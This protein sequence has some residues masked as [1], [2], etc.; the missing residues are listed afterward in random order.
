MA[1]IRIES[2]AKFAKAV[3]VVAFTV[4]IL[5]S[6][7]LWINEGRFFPV[8]KL[9]DSIPNP[10]AP[11]DLALPAVFVVLSLVWVFYDKKRIGLA[12]LGCLAV[13]L[14]QDQMRWQPWVYLYLLMLLS[15]LIPFDRTEREKSII[16]TLQWIIAGVYVWSGI[17][18][19]N[20]NFINGTFRLMVDA[21]GS[22]DLPQHWMKIGYAVPLVECS[23]GLALL[24]SRFRRA[25]VYMA[26]ATHIIIL[27]GLGPLGLSQ[28]TVVYPWN[29]AM[30]CFV[31]LLF[32]SPKEN[33]IA[34]LREVWSSKL[35]MMLVAP[36]WIFPV[37]NFF[38]Y[39]DHYLSFSLYSDKPSKFYIAIEQSELNKMDKRFEEYFVN[40]PGLQGGQII[41][42][43]KWAFSELNVPFYPEVRCFKKLSMGFC[44]MGMNTDKVVFL[45]LFKK[46]GQSGYNKFSC[47]DFEN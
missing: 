24:T 26:V 39:W 23:I 31:L 44:E 1:N 20:P 7:K 22:A 38:G 16:T 18:K 3:I 8:V 2:Q 36:V 27:A 32:W 5:L 17:Q 25:G 12:A 6:P 10:A 14:C 19:L 13:M 45:E 37:L 35:A 41:D 33:H 42:V 9:F 34:N 15:Y 30:V 46:G 4:G 21:I 43:D 28:N 40:I 11:F 47:S 29:I